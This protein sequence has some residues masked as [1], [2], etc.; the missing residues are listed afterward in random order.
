MIIG[1][2]GYA[3]VGKN[4]AADMLPAFTQLAFAD[5]LRQM[6]TYLDP[7]LT[8]KD[9]DKYIIPVNKHGHYTELVNTYGYEWVKDNTDAREFMVRLGAGARNLLDPDVWILPVKQRLLR[10]E[11]EDFVVTDVRY[12]NEVKM[13]K[14]LGGQVWYISRPGYGAA[15]DEERGSVGRILESGLVDAKILNTAGLDYLQDRVYMLTSRMYHEQHELL[16]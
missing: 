6:T 3:R 4:T 7:L 10:E 14:N 1:L 11:G 13:I 2:A 8:I 16:S 9:H 15:N 12:I 5:R